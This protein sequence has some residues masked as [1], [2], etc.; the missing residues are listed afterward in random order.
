MIEASELRQDPVTGKWVGIATERARRPQEYAQMQAVRTLLPPF[1]DTCPFCNLKEFPQAPPTLVEPRGARWKV[2]AFPNKFPA[3]V[4]RARVRARKRGPYTVMDGV[5]FH[6][7]IIVRAHNGALS[8]LPPEDA[9]LYVRAWRD[10]F[11][12]LMKHPSVAYLQ[13]IEN[14]GRE[15]GGSQEHPHMQLFAI[16]VLP[17]DEVQ[18]LLQGAEAYFEENSSC[19]YCDILSFER[20]TKERLVWE[21]A[22]FTVL[23]PF[24]SRVPSEQWVL[25]RRHSAGFETLRDD[26]IPAFVAALQE[27]L[28]RLDQGFRDPPYNLYLYSAPCG[29]KG[30]V[31]EA[32]EFQHFHWHAQILPRMT[33]WG[34]FELATGLELHSVLPE[35]AAAYLRTR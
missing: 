17:S 27:A 8:R 22:A 3:F 4:P 34:G 7:V 1:V 15:S 31:C 6:E 13:L 30:A 11:R 33:V 18:D 26:Q 19:A 2:R 5:G 25:P 28:R 20:D 29:T 32:A 35:E 12:S 14:H 16:P 23:C 10:R 24:S 9:R 21:N